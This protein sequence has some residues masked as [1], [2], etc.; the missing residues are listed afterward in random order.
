MADAAGVLHSLQFI[1]ADGTKRF[2][3]GGHVAGCFFT[4][5]DKAQGPL[6]IAEGCATGASVHE[7]TGFA[8]VCAMNAGNLKAVAE[9]LRAKWPER[10]I[11]IAADNDAWTDGNPGVAKA[12]TAAKG[13]GE[14]W[15]LHSSPTWRAN[16]QTS[17]IFTVWPDS[18][19]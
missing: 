13:I 16:R 6:V 2:L 17:T 19:K 11:V 12:T 4:I 8:V 3:R 10:E 18:P 1:G 9:A 7:A 5:A 14:N 15:P